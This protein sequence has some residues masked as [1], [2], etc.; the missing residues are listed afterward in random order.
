MRKAL[1]IF[2]LAG[3]IT[4]PL[5]ARPIDPV[6][7]MLEIKHQQPY[8]VKNV[9]LDRDLNY[10][11]ED[12]SMETG[13]RGEP[14]RDRYDD[15]EPIGDVA[16]GDDFLSGFTWYD[17]QANGTIAPPDWTGIPVPRRSLSRQCAP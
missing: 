1:L 10:S 14:G 6:D 13:M 2:I 7:P 4:A 17:Y 15:I 12:N 3:L 16:I 5:V 11:S 9:G 8:M